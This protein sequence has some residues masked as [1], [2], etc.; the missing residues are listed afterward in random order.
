MNVDF[1][2]PIDGVLGA[3]I[4]VLPSL[5][6]A[7]A[8]VIA[9]LVAAPIVAKVIRII[10]QR[11]G[12]ETLLERLGAPRLLYRIGYKMGAA[13]LIGSIGRFAVY[14]VTALLAA[15]IAG[16]TQIANGLDVVIGYLPR[17][18]VAVVFLMVGFWAAETVRSVVS[19]VTTNGQSSVVGAILY[20]GIGA[21]TV[22]LVADQLGLETA[23][24]NN[25]ILIVIASGAAAA[26]IGGGLS[27]RPTLA[28][29]LARNYVIQLYQR[30]DTVQIDGVEGIVKSHAPTALV[31][32]GEDFTYNI[33]YVRFMESAVAT[34]GEARPVRQGGEGADEEEATH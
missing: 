1:S 14:L 10:V 13:R 3:F 17:V 5:L 4:A 18:A 22:A 19:G 33:P 28:N 24:I 30:G 16:L 26:A 34:T 31:V 29:L 32:V 9:G 7:L 6:T 23:L 15:D 8:V 20:Y 27:A 2:A 21:I 11:T 12:M 25:I